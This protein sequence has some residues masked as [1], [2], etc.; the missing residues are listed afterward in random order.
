MNKTTINVRNLKPA[1]LIVT[2]YLLLF[3]FSSNAQGIGISSATIVPDPSSMLE[4]Q[5]SDKGLLIPRVALT[6]TGDVATIASPATSLLVYNTATAGD[7]VEGYYYWDVVW[8]PVAGPAAYYEED[9]TTNVAHTVDT[10][11]V[12]GMIITTAAGGNYRTEAVL[13]YTAVGG[14]IVTQAVTDHNALRAALMALAETNPGHAATFG[15]GETISRTT[16]DTVVMDV[17][18]AASLSGN[19][20]FDADDNPNTI[21]VIR[22][23]ST[24]TA[25][26]TAT[27]TLTGGAQ[28]CNIFWVA[29]STVAVTGA[30]NI[31]GTYMSGTTSTVAALSIIHG[32]LFAVAGAIAL[33]TVS[34]FTVPTGTST[35]TMGVLNTFIVFSNL[36]AVTATALSA[37]NFTGD[38][39]TVTALG[40]TGWEGLNGNTYFGTTSLGFIGSFVMALDGVPIESTRIVASGSSVSFPGKT[41]TTG[42]NGV[43]TIM[44]YIKLGTMTTGNRNIFA[45][46]LAD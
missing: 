40:N 39:G 32:R 6:G 24:F 38:V 43:I 26:A 12:D 35:L 7:V 30:A 37:L 18:G 21:F 15:A 5:A 10:A 36:G 1:A 29:G 41:I 14:D 3:T 11:N 25:A 16:K 44:N 22:A 46:R 34:S 45:L 31:V 4:I 17:S 19:I 28:A 42:A 23:T 33:T 27:Y 8:K 9:A 2:F 13:N 20:T